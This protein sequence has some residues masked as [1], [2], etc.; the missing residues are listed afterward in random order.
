MAHTHHHYDYIV[1]GGGSAGSGTGR[2][3]AAW[4]GA[5]TLMI[6]NGKSGGT[7]VNV[8]C[9]PKKM[10]WLFASVNETIRDS[11]F[12]GF[13]TS[14]VPFDFAEFK[15]KRDTAIKGLNAAY[16]R[17]WSHDS[18]ELVHGTARFVG[19]HE[20]EVTSL[21]STSKTTYTA[22]HIC[23]AT[24]GY[25]IIPKNIPG[26]E[27]GISSDGFF[28]ISDLPKRVAVAGAG[29]IAVE[30]AGVFN[31]IGVKVDIFIRGQTLLR[32][33]DTTVQDVIT[34]HYED[35]G[36]T[37]H[38]ETTIESVEK[39]KDGTGEA[40]VLRLTDSAGKTHEVNEVL[41][42][43]G[44][45]PEVGKLE[46]DKIGVK[47]SPSG[48]IAVDEFQNTSVKGIYAIGDVT[49]Q[50]ELTPVAIA[51]GR[52]LGNRLFGPPELS[53]SKLVYENVPSVVF[54]H[55][56]VGSVG[57]TESQARKTY[58]DETIKVYNTSFKHM[59]FDLFPAEERAKNPTVYK[60]VCQGP[61][62]K[63]VGLHLIGVDSAEILQGFGVA[64]K[65]GATKK[66][67][68][69]CV[70]IHPTSAEEIVTMK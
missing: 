31:A 41:W 51:A 64:V 35:I 40:K 19:P 26:A 12:Y 62:E 13:K 61:N 50:I 60:I 56:P 59:Y 9:V 47:T 16:E 23:I 58:G 38:R 25:P 22:P 17:N 66:D 24:G 3:A 36:I 33:F 43:I 37:I 49:G 45:S 69:S 39:I 52:Q 54:S 48:H 44:R 7:C 8:G 20:I 63:V 14:K 2:R 65:M 57:L 42:A 32:K 6:E 21:D 28:A 11:P 46:L 4:Y 30:L 67:F 29:Y 5:K 1:I 55:P 68:D 18:V 15:E 10:T 53:S 27:H 70:A 34:K